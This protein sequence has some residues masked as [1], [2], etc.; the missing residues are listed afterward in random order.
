MPDEKSLRAKAQKDAS[1]DQPSTEEAV[2]ATE[3]S[4][5]QDGGEEAGAVMST[6]VTLTPFEEQLRQREQLQRLKR[7]LYRKYHGKP[8]R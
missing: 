4:E 3:P 6:V 7:E 2:A 5:P 8:L 1:A